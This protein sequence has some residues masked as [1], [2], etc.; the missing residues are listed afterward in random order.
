MIRVR[1][2]RLQ[3]SLDCDVAVCGGTLGL[4]LALALQASTGMSAEVSL[5]GLDKGNRQLFTL[6]SGHMSLPAH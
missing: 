2:R 5:C 3:Q 4:L 1:H 6:T